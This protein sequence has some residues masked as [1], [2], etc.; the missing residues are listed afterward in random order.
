MFRHRLCERCLYLELVWP[1]LCHILSEYGSLLCKSLHSVRIWENFHTIKNS[2]RGHFSH[3]GQVLWFISLNLFLCLDLEISSFLW[4]RIL[5]MRLCFEFFESPIFLQKFCICPMFFIIE[6]FSIFNHENHSIIKNIGQVQN[7]QRN[8][9]DFKNSKWHCKYN[10]IFKEDA[11]PRKRT[12]I[13]YLCLNEKL[14]IIKYQGN[15]FL[16]Q[17]NEP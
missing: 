9:G 8:T 4:F 17:G 13:C 10:F 2:E 16:N 6:W 11:D 15:N 12:S 5:H 3:S 7:F 14:L 1:L